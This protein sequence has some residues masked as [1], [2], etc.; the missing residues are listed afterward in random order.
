MKVGGEGELG[1]TWDGDG[2]GPGS[3]ESG[4]GRAVEREGKSAVGGEEASGPFR[5]SL[6]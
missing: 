1:G 6:F 4:V 2:N 5:C 3:G